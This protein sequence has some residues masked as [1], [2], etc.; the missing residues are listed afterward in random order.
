MAGLC[1]KCE[2][3]ITRVS[4]EKVDVTQGSQAKWLGVS[5]S[6]PWCMTILS[7]GIDPIALKTDTINGVVSQLQDR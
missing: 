2:K 7:V 1:P 5:Y 4:L 3:P 6:C